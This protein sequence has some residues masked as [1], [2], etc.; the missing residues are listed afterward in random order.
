MRIKTKIKSL[1]LGAVIFL[2][3]IACMFLIY[4]SFLDIK[5]NQSSI[6]DIFNSVK[7]DSVQNINNNINSHDVKLV[8]VGDIM[9]SRGVNARMVKNGD[10]YPFLKVV[11]YLKSGDIVFG[12]L[13]SPI[14]LGDTIA[15]DGTVFRARPGVE[16]SLKNAGFNMLS[17]ANNHMGNQGQIGVEYTINSLKSVLINTSGAGKDYNSAHAPA[18]IEK[19]GLKFAFLSYTDGSI[20]PDSYEAKNNNYGVAYMDEDKLKEDISKAKKLADF[21]IVSMHAG[22]EYTYRPTQKQISFAHTA[23]DSGAELVLGHHPHQIQDVENYKGKYIFYSLGNF[24]FDQ[25][26]SKET[27]QGL[28]AEI[29]FNKSGLSDYNLTPVL[30]SDYAQPNILSDDDAASVFKSIKR[31]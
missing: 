22:L 5:N 15:L 1:L 30:I 24:V 4:G 17:L 23:I 10:D 31:P 28:L 9:L 19:N 2:T 20:I 11:D 12:N 8:A 25:E 27:K 3:L 16:K 18:I 14:A 13:E 29:Y 26:W 6:L 7:T 21:V